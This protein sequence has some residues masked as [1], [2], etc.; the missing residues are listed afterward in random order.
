M[1]GVIVKFDFTEI[2]TQYDS[3][4]KN[5]IEALNNERLRC[6][7]VDSR[8]SEVAHIIEY[9]DLSASEMSKFYKYLKVL[10]RIRRCHKERSIVF[11]NIIVHHKNPVDELKE[12]DV[13]VNRYRKEAE[14]SYKNF[15]KTEC[16]LEQD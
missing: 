8:I 1:V 9:K 4:H 2:V 13:R 6:K 14:L 16:N 11:Q 10:Y 7:K 5:M 3:A 12:S 15:H